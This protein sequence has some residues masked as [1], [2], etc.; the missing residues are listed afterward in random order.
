MNNNVLFL[1]SFILRIHEGPDNSTE[2]FKNNNNNKNK[3][4]RNGGKQ[5]KTLN[6]YDFD[7][8]FQ[9]TN[10]PKS[11]YFKIHKMFIFML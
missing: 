1:G 11:F 7:L 3:K 10:F 9:I 6:F 5:K 8:F 4:K 2:K